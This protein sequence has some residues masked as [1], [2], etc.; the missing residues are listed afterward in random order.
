MKLIERTTYMEKLRGVE[1]TPDIKV[2]TGIRRSGKSKLMEAFMADVTHRDPT[3]N[4]IHI[5]FNRTDTEPLREYHALESHVEGRF[6]PGVA[7]LLMI[8][9][10]QM[11]EGFERAINSLHASEKYD[12]YITGSDAF[13][14]SSDLATLFTG[15][16]FEIRVYPFSFAEYI[17]YHG[18]TGLQDSLDDYL[19]DGG[20][21][22]SYV[23]SS[24]EDRY[25]YVAEIYSTLIAR[26]ILQKYKIRNAPLLDRIN[27]YLMDN[28]SNAFS[29]RNASD[30][31][32]R[33][34]LDVNDKTVGSYI[35]YL[36]AAYAFY[37]VR[38]Y[39]IRGKRY[40]A[41]QDKYYL[42]DHSFRRARLGS[43]YLDYC[44]IYE[45][46]VAIELMRRGYEVYVGKLYQKEIDFVAIRR[47]EKIY[48]QVSDDITS[49]S[50]FEREVSP[51]LSIKDAYPK[52]LIARTRHEPS[53]YQGIQVIDLAEWLKGE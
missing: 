13:L 46:M 7:N 15:R 19:R 5:N 26:D 24:L 8:D 2:L 29:L 25:D 14:L 21:P 41:S 32:N 34:G 44:R 4:V 6:R 48:L 31:L 18:S 23:Y 40:L 51:L 3:A 9:E 37:R 36:C 30:A 43:R 49:P 33:G 38:R 53:V 42:A 10:V 1:G 39:D 22:G 35:G 20:M 28:T 47:S 11:C 16:T 17:I 52:Y 45:N 27:D 50:T 12:I